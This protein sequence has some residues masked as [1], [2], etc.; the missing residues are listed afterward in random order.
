MKKYKRI[1]LFLTAFA[2]GALIFALPCAAAHASNGAA[3]IKSFSHESATS[4]DFSNYDV[5]LTVPFA[6]PE[7][8]VDLTK[9]NYD[10][11]FS[12]YDS[13]GRAFS[14]N[15]AIVDDKGGPVIMTVSFCVNAEQKP[16][17]V[18]TTE[19]RIRAV[20]TQA[21]PAQFSGS[22]ER[23]VT[24]PKTAITFSADDF[25]SRYT[26]NQGGA[27]TGITIA[28]TD[29]QAGRF[30]Y[31]DSNYAL[32]TPIPIG[33]ISSLRFE[34]AASG[35]A[36]Y[37]VY[38]HNTDIASAARV[39]EA[40]L[41]LTVYPE[42][43]PSRDLDDIQYTIAWNNYVYLDDWDFNSVFRSLTGRTLY[44]IK[45][46]QPSSSYGRLYY[47]Y[48]SSDSYDFVISS[49]DRYYFDSSPR[50]SNITFVPRDDYTGSLTI[51]YTA[52]DS[53]MREYYGTI[54]IRVDNTG[55]YYNPGGSNNI[56][57]QANTVTYSTDIGAAVYLSSADF[58]AALA[59][60]ASNALSYIR[61][62]SLPSSGTGSLRYNYSGA[63]SS[64]VSYGDVTTDSRYYVNAPPEISKISFV[65]NASYAGTVN[66]PFTAFAVNGSAYGGTLYI[67]VGQAAASA[68]T[69]G[70]VNYT[71]KKNAAVKFSE[72]DFQAA[73]TKTIN[74]TLSYIMI[75]ELP[76][77]GTLY[78]NYRGDKNYDS[79]VTASARY[80][81]ASNPLISLISF[82]PKAGASGKI[83][84]P[85]T[86][87]TVNGAQ[88]GGKIVIT[89]A[90]SG[91]LKTLTYPL[92]AGGVLSF[93][94]R[95][96]DADIRAA[97]RQ[98][99]G[100]AASDAL[101][102][103]VFS[104]PPASAGTLYKNYSAGPGQR[105][106]VKEEEK[107]HDKA[108]PPLSALTF[109]PASVENARLNYTAF[110]EAGASYTGKI[111]IKP[112]SLPDSWARDEI[113]SLAQR[114]VIP[115]GILSDY[116]AKITRAEFTALMVN[117]CNYAGAADTGAPGRAATFEDIR[118]NP[119]VKH[120][121]A[122]YLYGIIDGV[123][124]TRFEPDASLTRE[125]AAKIL[126]A[127]VGRINGI[128]AVSQAPVAYDDQNKISD[129]ALPFVAYAKEHGLMIGDLENRF[130]PQDSITRE[131]AMALVERTIIKYRL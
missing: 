16:D 44:C 60:A 29:G 7:T 49:D 90:S 34:A 73:L 55:D 18:Y 79:A 96:I 116:G 82:V 62:Y 28:G 97:V 37:A 118:G 130:N 59:S 25:S 100:A 113:E 88:Y 107:F 53:D 65:P 3:V 19:Y 86:A 120:I 42:P 123:S 30:R 26:P 69:L 75:K 6:Y 104:V 98:A 22:I 61:F 129:W 102:Y 92:I 17:A 95:G 21:V 35:T 99:A 122:G 81:R 85:Y 38:A 2:A 119:Y 11:D 105:Q 36:T 32:G 48:S 9:L 93:S 71:V 76:S 111:T 1:V 45:I 64:L 68:Y 56:Y 54:R 46:S 91:S 112:L 131:E 128:T 72:G 80:Y 14:G 84:I 58:T 23:S 33:N 121:R 24:L 57:T 47:N 103:V 15:A 12:L 78:F 83:T 127:A 52:Y 125:A 124:N 74:S 126:C 117:T 87:Y 8:T 114:G 66:I 4:V 10:F 40:S 20:R 89:V 110:T 106:S 70:D 94:D 39:G 63:G 13:R 115:D 31:G 43:Y 51:G 41:K 67:R 50:I 77:G 109:A 5:T 108:S 27:I 101:S